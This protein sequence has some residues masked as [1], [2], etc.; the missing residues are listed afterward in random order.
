MCYCVRSFWLIQNDQKSK[1]SRCCLKL[2][3]FCAI[4]VW[5]TNLRHLG[6]ILFWRF[7]DP[8]VSPYRFENASPWGGI[9]YDSGESWRFI[10]LKS[11]VFYPFKSFLPPFTNTD[12]MWNIGHIHLKIENLNGQKGVKNFWGGKKLF[13]IKYESS[14]FQRRVDYFSTRLSYFSKLNWIL[15]ILKIWSWFSKMKK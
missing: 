6:G 10:F 14:R 4:F 13:S 8:T 5:N 12:E 1:H 9:L 2:F 3:R 11:K 15:N 7:F